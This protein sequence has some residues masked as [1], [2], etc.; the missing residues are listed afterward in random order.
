MLLLPST[1]FWLSALT[2]GPPP[3]P[4]DD[5]SG[6]A[7]PAEAVLT[8][9]QERA[10]ALHGAGA[11]LLTAGEFEPALQTLDKSIAADPELAEAYRTRSRAHEGLAGD[12]GTR[13]VLESAERDPDRF[14]PVLARLNAALT[15]AERYADKSGDGSEDD[16][17]EDLRARV[18]LAEALVAPAEP[19][20][21]ASN[22][23]PIVES[24]PP[25]SSTEDLE[26]EQALRRLG[27][28][29]IALG[30]IHASGAVFALGSWGLDANARGDVGRGIRP[31][32]LSAASVAVGLG[33]AAGGTG[34]FFLARYR[35]DGS[36]QGQRRMRLASIGPF[37]V[38][39]GLLGAGV[40][41]AVLGSTAWD[42]AATD[43]G[44]ALRSA[45]HRQN[46][47][48]TLSLASAPLLATGIGMVVGA[49]GSSEDEPAAQQTA[50]TPSRPFVRPTFSLRPRQG[51]SVGLSG[52]F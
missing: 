18:E 40:A 8:P 10:R 50:A 4:S 51:V 47:G 12:D 11:Q 17:I 32:H 33:S 24:P 49:G 23:A 7:A 22:E 19:D 16:R 29:L 13:E 41:L 43:D 20:D 36:K 39:G 42:S 44:P 28:S 31:G 27:G 46:V 38:G 2:L 48:M 1:A 26:R 3:P 15:D 9:D 6:D 21:A 35:R 45:I 30:V 52:A 14:E 37:A 5:P 34:G 25:T